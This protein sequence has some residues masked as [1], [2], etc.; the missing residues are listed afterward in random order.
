MMRHVRGRL[1]NG[2]C[3]RL[4]DRNG[5]GRKGLIGGETCPREVGQRTLSR[6]HGHQ[7][8]WGCEGRLMVSHVRVRLVNGLCHGLTDGNGLGGAMG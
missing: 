7:R 6:I 8:I 2:L 3:H 5:F 4:T 1:V